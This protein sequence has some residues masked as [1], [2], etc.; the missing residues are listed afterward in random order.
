MLFSVLNARR[1]RLTAPATFAQPA[2]FAV[3]TAPPPL[4][5]PP[6]PPQSPSIET[7]PQ[8]A[9][10]ESRPEPQPAPPSTTIQPQIIYQ[11]EPMPVQAPP[12]I[13]REVGG[14]A[15]VLDVTQGKAPGD[16]VN[17]SENSAVGATAASEGARSA[18]NRVHAGAFANRSTTVPQGTLI[19]AVLETAFDST[20][21]GFA[22]A[23]VQRD[24][25]GFDG[26]RVLIPRGS[27]LIGEYDTNTASGQ[28]RAM[29]VWFRLVRPDGA[30]IAIGSPAADPVGRGGVRAR[31]NS[32]FFERFTGAILQSSLDV[33]VNLASRSNGSPVIVALPS[34]NQSTRDIVRP[35]EIKPTLK[36]AQGTSIA[37][38]VARDLDFSEVENE[39]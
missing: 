39:R 16:G 2:D 26:T 18:N 23:L 25:K 30:T 21:A 34:V 36:V 22:R 11:Q 7:I 37:V 17:A 14:S 38:F 31:V 27:R 6:V 3:N 29:V 4:I 20:R 35:A 5:L 8:H 33:G 10:A 1:A 13:S 15:L 12:S 24:I 19:P 32:H 9:Q 28:N